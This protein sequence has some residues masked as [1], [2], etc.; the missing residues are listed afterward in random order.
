MKFR[1]PEIERRMR[2]HGKT[3]VGTDLLY[4]WEIYTVVSIDLETEGVRIRS[5]GGESFPLHVGRYKVEAA[6]LRGMPRKLSWVL[7]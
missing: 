5:R 3:M 4:G 7:V 2:D 1:I 6:N